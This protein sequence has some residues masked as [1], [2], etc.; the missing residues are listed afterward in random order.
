MLYISI[1]AE[2]GLEPTTFG[3]WAPSILMSSVV[4]S[5]ILLFISINIS[6][7]Y[8]GIFDIS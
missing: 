3:L 4:N 1:V 6:P 2:V 7:L 8:S 5:G